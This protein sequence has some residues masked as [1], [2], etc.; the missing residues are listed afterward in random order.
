M[1]DKQHLWD[2]DDD[3]VDKSISAISSGRG[4]LQARAGGE[5]WGGD[6][7]VGDDDADES[8]AVDAEESADASDDAEGYQAASQWRR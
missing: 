1:P 5:G 6:H 7:A 2:N 8:A 4:L 3:G